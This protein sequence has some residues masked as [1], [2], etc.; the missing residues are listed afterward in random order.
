[1]GEDCELETLIAS[2]RDSTLRS[3]S[4][5]ENNKKH[6]KDIQYLPPVHVNITWC[7]W[8][9]Y[10][11]CLTSLATILT[12][13]PRNICSKNMT[14]YRTALPIVL[15][16]LSAGLSIALLV[17]SIIVYLKSKKIRSSSS[18]TTSSSHASSAVASSHASSTAASSQASS[19]AASSQASSVASSHASS[20]TSSQASSAAASSVASSHASSAAASSVAPPV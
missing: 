20:A 2:G 3:Y 7:I 14:K 11:L 19:T 9:K 5:F 16:G 18:S 15:S 8:Q 17:G 6:F 13:K 12:K 10:L 1:M 4:L